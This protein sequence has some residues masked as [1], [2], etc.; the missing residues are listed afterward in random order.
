MFFL[1]SFWTLVGWRISGRSVVV[2]QPRFPSHSHQMLLLSGRDTKD[3]LVIFPPTPT[4]RHYRLAARF[5]LY[6]VFFSL[7][8][9]WRLKT[10]DDWRFR[11]IFVFF[12]TRTSQ[13]N[14]GRDEQAFSHP[15]AA[16]LALCLQPPAGKECMDVWKPA[17]QRRPAGGS[18]F[19]TLP[20]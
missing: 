10:Q 16:C 6:F 1:L 11:F 4:T 20:F 19:C 15:I 18:T 3:W 13:T 9:D 2:F 8:T 5:A 12:V 14:K 7:E 17:N